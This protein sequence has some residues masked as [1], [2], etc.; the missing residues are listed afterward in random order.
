MKIDNEFP[1]TEE[2]MRRQILFVAL[3]SLLA[4]SPAATHIKTES[5]D[6]D[7]GWDSFNNRQ[8][9]DKYPTVIQDFG[10]APDQKAIG[11]TITRTSTPAWYALKL[12]QALDL[13]QPLSFSGTFSV[14]KAQ[15]GTIHFGFFNPTMLRDGG[16]PPGS[17]ML[18]LDGAKTFV[19]GFVRVIA[20]DNQQTG[21]LVPPAQKV[22]SATPISADGS[23]HHF[24][25]TYDPHA[26][27]EQGQFHATIDNL[28]QATFEL[29]P[30][31]KSQ[32]FSFTHFGLL[33]SQ[34]SG[35]PMKAYFSDLKYNATPIDLAADPKWESHGNH[36]T[37][38]DHDLA[39]FQN[40]GY[41]HVE[42]RPHGALGGTV[43][44]SERPSFYAD[45]IAT[46]TLDQPLK[47]SGTLAFSVGAPDSGAFLAFFNANDL[48]SL[49]RQNL[50]GIH[51]EGPSRVGHYIRPIL[52]TSTGKRVA[53]ETGPVVPV[54]NK[55]RPFTLE[56]DPSTRKLTLTFDGKTQTLDVPETVLNE[57]ATFDHF[58]LF[59]SLAGG[60]QVQLH[61]DN[62]TYTTARP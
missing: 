13:T 35:S 2:P 40:Y 46:L 45:N 20:P 11:G 10:Y 18:F 49:K 1:L 59:P 30:G 58:G 3:L 33:N 28:P 4:A 60:S 14:P 27:Q 9:P 48:K 61:F 53:P 21:S 38:E 16:R 56:F 5:F 6:H 8:T 52:Y 24:T 39:G 36:A 51:I 19:R 44:R 41:L 55:P 42:P 29:R 12:P 54:D 26:N 37:F 34:K 23:K 50:L 22:K 7:P 31:M 43:W 15:G 62:L 57:G 47:I 32:P 17:V 25:V